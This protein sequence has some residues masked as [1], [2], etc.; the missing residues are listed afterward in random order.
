VLEAQLQTF[1]EADAIPKPNIDF[2]SNLNVLET[3]TFAADAPKRE[4]NSNI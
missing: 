4:A 1:N 3:A 2:S